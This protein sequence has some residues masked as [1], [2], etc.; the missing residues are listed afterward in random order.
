MKLR[1]S[2]TF[3]DYSCTCGPLELLGV[4][5]DFSKKIAKNIFFEK[6]TENTAGGLPEKHEKIS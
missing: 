2:R 3:C 6:T 4:W 5:I 1:E